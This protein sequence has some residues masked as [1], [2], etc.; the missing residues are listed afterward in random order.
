[1]WGRLFIKTSFQRSARWL[2]AILCAAIAC[3]GAVG[4]KQGQAATGS[5][6][7][8]AAAISLR[9][10][11]PELTRAFRQRQSAAEISVTYGASGVLRK[12]VEG[13]ASID[14]VFFANAEPVDALI[15]GG[16]ADASTKRVVA[17]NQ[18]I[19]IGPKGGRRV[20]FDRLTSV[21]TDEKIAIGDPKTVP[22]GQ[23]AREALKKLGNWEALQNRLVFGGD[24]AAVLAY[25]RR[26]EVA[27]AV[28]Y[29]TEVRGLTDVEVW[30]EAKG[31]WAPRAE[32][33]S[34]VVKGGGDY[35][36]SAQFVAYASAPEGQEILR[37]FG[38]GPP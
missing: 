8:V 4:C 15:R 30:D 2:S 29:R 20:T 36:R 24:V 26:G 31:E 38:F 6:L 3:L 19:L 9:Q 1:M 23:Y 35:A 14:A 21:P 34:A 12:Q 5:S 7:T 11:M 28:V 22:A 18:L 17:T 10:V 37:A 16:Y 13:G 25:A 32:V 33:V 27:A